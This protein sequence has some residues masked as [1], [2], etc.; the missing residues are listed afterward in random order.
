[1]YQT[2]YIIYV[3]THPHYLFFFLS[4]YPTSKAAAIARNLLFD[5][6]ESERFLTEATIMPM[7]EQIRHL[8]ATNMVFVALLEPIVLFRAHLDALSEDMQHLPD[9]DHIQRYVSNN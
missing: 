4:L 3:G 1:M 7:P 6:S 9:D 5:D 8:F 2:C